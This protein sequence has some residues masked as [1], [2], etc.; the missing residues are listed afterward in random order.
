MMV[1]KTNYKIA[2]AHL[3]SRVKQTLVAILSV[4]FGISMYIFMNSFMT[5]V[6]DTQTGL[7]FSTLAHIRIYNDI[8]KD[9]TNLFDGHVDKNTLVNIRNP[10]VIKYTEG[11]KNSERILNILDTVPEISG[12]TP[13]LNI[14]VFFRNGATKINGMLSGIDVVN[15]DRLFGT[16]QYVTEGDWMD[17]QRRSDGI[18]LGSGLAKKL[19]LG[20][21]DNVV[22]TTEDG[23]T[24]NYKVIGIVETTL[25]S[26]DN[27]KAYIRIGFARQLVSKNMGYVTD[28]QINLNDY[29]DTWALAERL[30]QHTEYKVEP[31]QEANGQLEAANKLRNIIALAVSL[32]IL[33]VAGFGIY[34]IMNMTVNEKIREIAI[35]KAMGFDGRDIVQIFLTQSIIIGILG[36]MVGI[37]LGYLVSVGVNHI[38]FKIASLETL[39]IT[40]RTSDYVLA[41]VF[42]MI[43]TYI[44]GYLPAKKASKVDPVEIIRG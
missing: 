37:I 42:G 38:P 6:N 43:T 21:N 12:V 34:N 4:T 19:S 44:A 10:K 36:G 16:A 2:N 22:V 9:R 8:P 7:A 31:W 25:A 13:Q 40:Y 24:K 32:T 33:I 14:N 20:L 28:I 23:I 17:L 30:G 27:S 15:E 5:G 39:P 18:L 29:D 11:I 35:L 26:V 41:F 3:T 1:S